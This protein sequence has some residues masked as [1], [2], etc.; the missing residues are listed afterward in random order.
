[1]PDEGFFWRI[2]QGSLESPRFERVRSMVAEMSFSEGTVLSRRLVSLLWCMPLFMAW[3]AERV[4][5]GAGD[6]TIYANATMALMRSQTRSSGCSESL[7]FRAK[8]RGVP[9]SGLSGLRRCASP[10]PVAH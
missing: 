4:Q 6:A 3:Q 2:R 1:M 8:H 10:R 7:D 5:E 9:H